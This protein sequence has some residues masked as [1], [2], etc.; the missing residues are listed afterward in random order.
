MVT[1][2]HSDVHFRF[3]RPHAHRVYLVG[4]FNHWRVGDLPMTRAA[5]GHWTARL[6]LGPG[7]YRFRYWADGQWFVDYASFGVEHGPFGLDGIARVPPRTRPTAQDDSAR[8]AACA[9]CPLVGAAA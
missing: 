3:L 1:A 7:E 2:R 9:D 5:D 8:P 4:E 6:H